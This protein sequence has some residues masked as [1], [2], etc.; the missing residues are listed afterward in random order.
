MHGQNLKP[1]EFHK[2]RSPVSV[3]RPNPRCTRN[4]S[5][6]P[7]A[8]YHQ[9]QRSLRTYL[10]L[11]THVRRS[12]K[13]AIEKSY[14]G[15]YSGLTSRLKDQQS[16]V[17]CTK[18]VIWWNGHY[19]SNHL[20]GETKVVARFRRSGCHSPIVS[21]FLCSGGKGVA[22]EASLASQHSPSN[23]PPFLTPLHP[24]RLSSHLPLC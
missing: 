17:I 14:Y 1:T 23:K 8:W 20:L 21:S 22:F 3:P 18:M 15:T 7:N 9:T 12:N 2:E 6:R 19:I 16:T 13:E 4:A 10:W 24:L 5:Q 11:W